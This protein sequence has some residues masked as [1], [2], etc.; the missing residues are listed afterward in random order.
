MDGRIADAY[1]C[2]NP[3][4]S[5]TFNLSIQVMAQDRVRPERWF[6]WT[7]PQAVLSAWTGPGAAKLSAGEAITR[8][9]ADG[10]AI[11][12]SADTRDGCLGL[13]F[14][15]RRATPTYGRRLHQFSS[16][17]LPGSNVRAPQA[18]VWPA[19]SWT[20]SLGSQPFQRE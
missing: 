17:A 7:L 5:Q 10:A 8:A 18:Q 11:V 1:N 19:T 20:A 6:A 12:L 14:A 16:R 13:T 4:Y 3:S 15:P 9:G 2:F